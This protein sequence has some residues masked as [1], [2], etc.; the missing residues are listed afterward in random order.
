M[1]TLMLLPVGRVRNT[2]DT[3]SLLVRYVKRSLSIHTITLIIVTWI[4]GVGTIK[5][6]NLVS[7]LFV[8]R[9]LTLV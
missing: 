4:L 9:T 2:T 7:I 5:E 3:F 8:D 1:K 6:K